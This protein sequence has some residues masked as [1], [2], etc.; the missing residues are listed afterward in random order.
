MC[1]ICVIKGIFWLLGRKWLGY[2]ESGSR[3][4]NRLIASVI[5]A[6]I[7]LVF[8]GLQHALHMLPHL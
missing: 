2:G 1:H 8:K 5:R 7:S 6:G 4:I 3:P